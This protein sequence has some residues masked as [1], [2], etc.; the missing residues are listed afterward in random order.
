MPIYTYR[1]E[2]CGIQFDRRQKFED[3]PLTVCPDCEEESLRKVFQPVGILFK[4]SGFYSTDNRSTSGANRS[5]A[6]SEKES[7]DVAKD[8]K[9]KDT[10]TSKSTSTTSKD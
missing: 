9:K 3:I 10:E 2:N 8:T 7:G 6:K 5:G 1:C 4:G